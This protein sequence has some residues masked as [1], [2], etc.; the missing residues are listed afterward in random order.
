M[1]TL[2]ITPRRQRCA[3]NCRNGTVSS[4][5]AGSRKGHRMARWNIAKRLFIGIGGLVLLLLISGAVSFGTGRWLKAQLD[6]VTKRTAKQ[7]DLALRLQRDQVALSDLQRGLLLAAL[8]GEQAGVTDA[9]KKHASTRSEK[10][11][12]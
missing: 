3:R 1:R 9:Q 6:S 8:G 4:V 11:G 10:N 12:R 7:L 5:R 2:D